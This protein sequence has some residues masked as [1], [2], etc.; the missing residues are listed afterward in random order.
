MTSQNSEISTTSTSQSQITSDSSFSASA[1]DSV[2]TLTSSLS[3]LTTDSEISS[4]S[5]AY[6]TQDENLSQELSD[7]SEPDD[8]ENDPTWVPQMWAP[9][10]ES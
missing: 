4:L 6:D 5:S 2:S 9:S 3:T 10:L 7:W 1:S 8:E